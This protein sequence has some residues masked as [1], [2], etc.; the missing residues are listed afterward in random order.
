MEVLVTGG[1]G[2]IGSHV[3][4]AL[5]AAGHGVRVLDVLHPLAHAE[6][7][8]YLNPSVDY[9]WADVTDSTAVRDAVAGVNAVCHLAATVGLGRDFSDVDTYVEDN[10]LGTARLLRALHHRDFRG[11]FVLAS[12]MAVYGEGQYRCRRHGSVP[13]A[14]R[15][16]EAV[17]LGIFDPPC[18]HC[19]QA[20]I[21]RPVTEDTAPDPRSVYAATKLHQEHL[22]LAFGHRQQVA[23]TALRYHN[24]YGP[25]MPA[26]TPY[27]GVASIFRSALEQGH[28]PRVLEDGAQLRDFVHVADAATATVR[29][30]TIPEPVGG[31]INIA[32]GTPRTV[33]QFADTLHQVATSHG[34]PPIVAGGTRPGDVRHMFGDT[35]RAL[36]RLGF[37]PEIPFESGV[38][39]FVRHP[40]RA[41]VSQA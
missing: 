18:P 15:T 4:D 19:G 16:P 10:D 39:D 8:G 9:R 41:P 1:A 12:S 32:T 5:V 29:A 11:P 3:V 37:T 34:P 31:P 33:L 14:P 23:V 17:D 20:L 6:P 13:P 40:L 27:A 21:P 38:A 30:L 22:C 36:T 24:V 28:A 7:P 26:N 2:F 25:R 35:D